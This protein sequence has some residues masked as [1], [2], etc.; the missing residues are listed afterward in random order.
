MAFRQVY[1]RPDRHGTSLHADATKLLAKLRAAGPGVAIEHLGDASMLPAEQPLAPVRE[2][3]RT[4]GDDFAHDVRTIE[5][6][7]WAGPIESP[8]GLHLVFV[9]ERTGGAKPAL[10]EIRPVVEREVQAERRNAQLQALYDR[11]LAKYA[12]TVEMPGEAP[13]SDA[14]EAK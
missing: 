10:S 9:G 14:R 2:V 12:I 5:P 1:L 7:V 11:L 3:A 13:A 8:F 6:G 4:F